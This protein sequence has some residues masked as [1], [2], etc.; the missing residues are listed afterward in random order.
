MWKLRQKRVSI[1]PDIEQAPRADTE[2]KH[3][4]TQDLMREHEGEQMHLLSISSCFTKDLKI[5]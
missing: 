3:R 5:L 1:S 2:M 4:K